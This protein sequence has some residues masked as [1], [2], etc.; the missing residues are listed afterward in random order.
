MIRIAIRAGLP[1]RLDLIHEPEAAAILCFVEDME[2]RLRL[3]DSE[4]EAAGVRSSSK[5]SGF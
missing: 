3:P 1:Q 2:S 4:H 5:V